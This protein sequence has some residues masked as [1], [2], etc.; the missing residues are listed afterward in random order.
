M[1]ST[2]GKKFI[3]F[4]FKVSS[5][6]STIYWDVF[7]RSEINNSAAVTAAETVEE[8]T[9]LQIPS[10]LPR[11]GREFFLM[12]WV[13]YL[14]KLRTTQVTDLIFE[15]FDY[16]IVQYIQLV[17]KDPQLWAYLEHICITTDSLI[18]MIF[19]FWKW[20]LSF[21]SIWISVSA[22]KVLSQINTDYCTA[23]GKQW[24]GVSFSL[25]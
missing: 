2:C 12:F 21:I 1:L 23:S 17:G 5:Q 3:G 13:N 22:L 15:R 10:S 20:V 8:I 18:F 25:L 6:K 11:E 9:F 24:Q 14:I 4:G 16:L 19:K 7:R